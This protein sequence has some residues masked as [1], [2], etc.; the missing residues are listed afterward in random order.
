MWWKSVIWTGILFGTFAWLVP[1]VL[2]LLSWGIGKL[3]A[4]VM[5]T[6]IRTDECC[7]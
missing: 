2:W 6:M 3:F 7:M 1:N 4:N 5:V